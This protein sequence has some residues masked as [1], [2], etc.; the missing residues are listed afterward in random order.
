MDDERWLTGW[1][2][3]GEY[4]G[5]AAKTAQRYGRMGLP[6]FRDPGGR[7]I[8]KPSM[9]DEFIVEYNQRRFEHG[10]WRDRGIGAALELVD[11]EEK[12]RK[13]FDE[14]VIEAQRKPRC[15]F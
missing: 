15:R 12:R 8:A 13:E 11:D 5:K 7:P 2:E 4:L 14:R 3:I 6:F 9:I 10:R 1:Q